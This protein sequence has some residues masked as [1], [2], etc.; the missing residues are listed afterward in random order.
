M[1][2]RAAT[3]CGGGLGDALGPIGLTYS[4]GIK[5]KEHASTSEEDAAAAAALPAPSIARMTTAEWREKYEKDG[6]VDL[7]MEEEFNAGSRLVGG[8]AVHWGGVAGSRTGEGPSTGGVPS[9]TITI[10][11]P[12]MGQTVTVDV[13]EDRYIL[14][15]AEDAGL[16]LPYACR[17]GCCTACAVRVKSGELRQVEALGVSQELRDAGYGL[18][19][20]GYPTSDCELEVVDEDEVYELQFGRAFAEA[21]LDP[22]SPHVERDDYALEIAQYDE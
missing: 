5:P 13:P 11:N 6:T 9:H 17:M 1:A 18:M 10:H 7:W 16:E 19:C 14:W 22:N 12:R 8:R 20:V 2:Q 15:E 21:A 4:G 3:L